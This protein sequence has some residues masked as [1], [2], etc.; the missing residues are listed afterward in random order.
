MKVFV[1]IRT[2]DYGNRCRAVFAKQEDAKI[3]CDKNNELQP[4]SWVDSYVEM[5]VQ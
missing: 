4:R 2:Y 3:F 5:E 1:V